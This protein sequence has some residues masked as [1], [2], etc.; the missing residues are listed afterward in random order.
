MSFHVNELE[1][2]LV[3]LYIEKALLEKGI[4][5]YDSVSENLYENYECY[6]EDC[7]EHPE[8]LTNVLKNLYEDD[9]R[10]VILSIKNDLKDFSRYK[11]IARFLEVLSNTR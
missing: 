11:R 5:A 6:L 1:R 8:Y 3:R 9:A 7:Y 2:V 10:D 4:F